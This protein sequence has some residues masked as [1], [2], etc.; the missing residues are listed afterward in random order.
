MFKWSSWPYTELYAKGVLDVPFSAHDFSVEQG[1]K[2]SKQAEQ[3][4]PGDTIFVVIFKGSIALPPPC[5]QS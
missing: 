4:V 5:S 3:V 2:R 1:T